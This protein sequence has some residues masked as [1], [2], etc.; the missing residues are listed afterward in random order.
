M[1]TVMLKLARESIQSHFRHKR[2]VSSSIL[3]E[4]PELE[5]QGASFVTLTKK[6]KLRG[7]IGSIIAH[8]TLFD[9][10][11]SNA[12][13]AAFNDPRFPPLSE[14]E[15]AQ[16]RIEVSILTQPKSLDYT[17]KDDLKEKITMGV[18]GVIL[19]SGYQQATFLPQV[20]EELNNFELFFSH[21]CN[22]AGLG[23]ECLQLHPEIS[24]YQVEKVK[25]NDFL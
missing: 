8:R 10:I 7:C 11:I 24:V 9:D 16:I 14:D 5:K 17:N 6:G 15:F 23:G 3:E 18:D 22:K 2:I 21:L 4:Y 13:S 1:K 12:K 25:E 20:W 19:K